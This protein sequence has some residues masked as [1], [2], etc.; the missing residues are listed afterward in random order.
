MSAVIEALECIIMKT[1]QLWLAAALG[2]AI[3]AQN[4]VVAADKSVAQQ[5]T[6]AAVQLAG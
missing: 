5:M 4:Q 1:Y 2:G 3:G 6:R